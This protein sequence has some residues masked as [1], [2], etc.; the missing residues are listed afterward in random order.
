MRGSD[1]E[2][3]LLDKPGEARGLT[4]RKVQHEARQGRRV[5][6]RMYER[7]LQAST[8]EPGVER[9]VAV[10]DQH[11]AVRETQEGAAGIAK[12]WCA[13]QHRAVDVVP[14]V[15]IWVDR[16]LAVHQG[17]EKGERAIE[18]EA[19]R[20]DLED[21]EWHVARAFDVQGDELRVIQAG[22]K[23][24]PGRVDGNLFPQHGLDRAARFQVNGSN[25]HE[26]RGYAVI[27]RGPLE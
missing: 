7:A 9:V 10:L 21:Q 5:D 6:D 11:R 8:D 23:A 19:L 3:K 2:S 4:L 16:S 24:K 13:D 22:L 20:P 14:P 15:R 25:P 17:V 27:S 1:V 18:I 12:L 26:I